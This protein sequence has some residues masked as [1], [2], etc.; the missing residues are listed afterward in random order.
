VS[1]YRNFDHGD[2]LPA[3]WTDAI[4]EYISTLA[5]N[6]DITTSAANTLKIAAA[7]GNGQAAIGIDGLW[8]YR[9]SDVTVV[10]SGA[11]GT[12]DIYVTATANSFS[13][14][15]SPDTDATDYNFGLSVVT[16]GGAAPSGGGIVATRK[17]GECEWDGTTNITAIRQLEGAQ[18]VTL[19]MTPTAPLA[20]V[21]PGRFIGATAHSANLIE[22]RVGLGGSN[23]FSVSSTGAI[24]SAGAITSAAGLDVTT[25]AFSSNVTIGG[26]LGVTG[27]AS[28]ASGSAGA[29]GMKFTSGVDGFYRIGGG[30][31]GHVAGGSERLRVHGDGDVSILGDVGIG[32]ALGTDPGY[33]LGVT[34]TF[35]ATGA[36]TLGSTLNVTGI[37]RTIG[38]LSNGTSSLG[39]NIAMRNEWVWSGDVAQTNYGLY[40]SITHRP[41]TAALGSNTRGAYFSMTMDDANAT[42]DI[43]G[44]GYGVYV[45]AEA[46]NNAATPRTLA[47]LTG[48]HVQTTYGSGTLGPVSTIYGVRVASSIPLA[49][50]GTRYGFYAD[51]LGMSAGGTVTT[52][53]GMR[54]EN[55]GAAGV[56]TSVALHIDA[57]SGSGTNWAIRAAGGQSYHVGNLRIGSTTAPTVALDVTGAGSFSSNVTVGGT[58]TGMTNVSGTGN[59]A[60]VSSPALT[61]TPTAPTAAVDTN[62][63]Q[64]ASTAYVVGQGYLKSAT[65]ASTYAP[66]ASPTF[67]GTV[68]I[69]TVAG[70]ADSTT[71][72]A[73]TAF[74]QAVVAASTPTGVGYLANT[75]TWAAVNT[76]S[77]KITASA[78]VLASGAGSDLI[79]FRNTASSDKAWTM[80]MSGNDLRIY[81][82]TT[83]IAGGGTDRVTFEAGGDVGIG[84]TNPSYKLDVNG[85]GHFVGAVTFDTASTHPTVAQGTNNTTLATTAFV[86]AAVA[87]A[88]P[89]G[90]AYLG[91]NQTWTGTNAFNNAVEMTAAATQAASTGTWKGPLHIEGASSSAAGVDY[92]S[93]ISFATDATSTYARIGALFG[94]SGSWLI[95]STSNN[96]A[97]GTTNQAMVI[98]YDGN[99]GI[100][101]ASPSYKLDVSGTTRF[102]GDMR[103]N[104]DYYN[105]QSAMAFVNDNG[106]A[107]AYF[108][109]LMDTGGGANVHMNL[110][111]AGL[112]IGDGTAAS[113]KLDVVG[114]ASVSSTLHAQNQFRMGGAG[115]LL[116]WGDWVGGT[117]RVIAGA[118][119]IESQRA[120]GMEIGSTSGP[121]ILYSGTTERFR[122]NSTG[123]GFYAQTP[124]AR[125]AARTTT[126]WTAPTDNQSSNNHG[127]RIVDR[128]SWTTENLFDFV[129]TMYND[130]KL[131]GLLA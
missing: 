45:N 95:F 51:S 113:Y 91:V 102:V 22:A 47:N 84:I 65:A 27:V 50:Y 62:T 122:V 82:Y 66:L 44:I 107:N 86:N 74:V 121:T 36:A 99:V 69:P 4:Q 100:N 25:G 77:S 40:N 10:V 21:V 15:P 17:I 68:T 35:N 114:D 71:K 96:Y 18:N 126:N 79:Q 43:T 111:T 112:R 80:Y 34:G 2:V 59:F 64:I 7:T 63:T 28:F 76:F 98:R 3:S 31:V 120:A 130:L 54:F 81:E 72:A 92:S 75:Q 97:S 19:P 127:R 58:L 57:Q 48:I 33:K 37:T 41:T 53:Y 101:Q 42:A 104:G 13:N 105:S 70:T 1:K 12:K 60:L 29:P 87:A 109:W 23:V 8:R 123:I 93:A 38:G 9:S 5:A 6:V 26:T 67:T 129:M 49:A 11:A 124:V 78:G 46:D 108:R 119:N 56:T 52:N 118:V 89:P 55:Q 30:G 117:N 110:R 39:T 128:S 94:G 32:A 14:S 83:T 73:S 115:G 20:T 61:G 88:A 131:S 106:T 90:A 116:V 85:T 16:S 24:S 103:H 125:A